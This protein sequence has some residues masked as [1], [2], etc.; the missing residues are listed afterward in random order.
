MNRDKFT[1]W[2]KNEEVDGFLHGTLL[3]CPWYAWAIGILLVYDA[4]C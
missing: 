3:G 1:D 4:I 2:L